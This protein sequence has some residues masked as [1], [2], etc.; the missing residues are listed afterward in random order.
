MKTTGMKHL[1]IVFL[2]L[3]SMTTFT[4]VFAETKNAAPRAIPV[5]KGPDA[6]F[7]TP[8]GDFLYVANV[9]DTFISV[10]DTKKDTVV[11]KIDTVDY[12]WGFTRLGKTNLVAVSGFDK[13]IDVIDSSIHKVVRS[14]RYK[15]NLGGIAS[16]NDGNTLFVVA[17]EENKI[18]KVDAKTL[19]IIDELKTGNGPDGVG[20]SQD[21]K[22]IFVTNTKDGTISVLDLNTKK[23]KLIS[24]GGKP[25]LIHSNEDHSLLYISNFALGKIHIVSTETD[26]I[27]NEIKGLNGAEEA[28][29][30][31]SGKTLYVV[32]YNIS[33]VYSYDAKTYQKRPEEFAVGK[34]PIGVIPSSDGRKLYVTNYGDN[35][36][37]IIPLP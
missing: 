28:V 17:A 1:R 12:P 22:K 34:N 27:I 8:Q 37:T 4:Q 2:F 31:K 36:V 32:N 7:L 19:R 33:K 15:M 26:N 10:I 13:G 35:S 21:N 20:I 24:T 25:E 11:H 6:M 18:L 5:G 14:I 16:T 3:L 23:G 9:E 30:S 29:L